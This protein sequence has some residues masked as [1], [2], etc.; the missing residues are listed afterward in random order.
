MTV[1]NKNRDG[2]WE[3]VK[4]DATENYTV[5]YYE[6]Y[7]ACGW[8]QIGAAESY[9]KEC[10]EYEFD[11]NLDET[12]K[13]EKEMKKFEVGAMYWDTS[14]VDHD[15]VMIIKI[16]RRTEKSVWFVRMHN[17]KE[18]GE[19]SRTKIFTDATREYIM[20]YKYSMAPVWEADRKVEDA[21]LRGYIEAA[22][23]A[24]Q[25]ATNGQ[26]E[27]KMTL[28][29]LYLDTMSKFENAEI[30]GVTVYTYGGDTVEDFDDVQSVI[31][32]YGNQEIEPVYLG[33][34]FPASMTEPDMYGRIH[35][36][37]PAV[38]EPDE[39]EHTETADD[40][41]AAGQPAPQA[42]AAPEGV[43]SVEAESETTADSAESAVFYY[44]IPRIANDRYIPV[45]RG[46]LAMSETLFH[47][48]I[49]GGYSNTPKTEITTEKVADD[50]FVTIVC[51]PAPCRYEI[52]SR[53]LEEAE[54]VFTEK[55]GTYLQP[56]QAA[57]FAAGMVD[58]GKYTIL[59]YNDFGELSAQKIRFHS[60][61]P[62]TYAQY[63]DA[64]QIVCTP[65][66]KRGKRVWTLYN[67]SFAIYAGWQDLPESATTE[68]LKETESVKVTKWKWRCWD[69]DGFT[70]CKGILKDCLTVYE[71]FKVSANG[72]K[73][74]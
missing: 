28:K 68:T 40:G 49:G 69:A 57:A 53:T 1:Y 62:T 44:E 50:C 14:A 52:V 8:K 58:G 37:L 3:I 16:T 2:K 42:D 31:N 71:D 39:D 56:L 73:F 55:R 23:Q 60:M 22:E 70:A 48:T 66:R 34:D 45:A 27:K 54:R 20:P 5:T 32:Y 43:E 74:A 72:R 18:D 15:D 6:R 41:A 67:K 12:V 11:I 36:A 63:G 25:P 46:K 47:A 65:F 17:G 19:P 7:D 30:C 21:A 51:N 26:E 33:G 38:V 4:N 10:A 24:G 64:V 61:E 59:C 35:V 29:E 13:E 9:S